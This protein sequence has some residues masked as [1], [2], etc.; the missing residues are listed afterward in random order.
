MSE[1]EPTEPNEKDRVTFGVSQ[2]GQTVLEA[3]ISQKFFKTELGAFQA[4]AAHALNLEL[5]LADVSTSNGTKWN[6]GSVS[7]Q[8][9]E[10]LEWYLPTATPV[11]AL[12]SLGNAGLASISDKAISGGYVYSEIF[13]LP[14]P[15]FE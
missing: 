11:R 13:Q 9:L 1:V 6:R 2:Q 12:E 3:L 15:A 8:L 5:P 14:K 7:P 10:F 4:A